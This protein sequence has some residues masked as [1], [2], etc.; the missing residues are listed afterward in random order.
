MELIGKV[1]AGRGVSDVDGGSDG[2]DGI[3]EFGIIVGG[4]GEL[5]D[6]GGLGGELGRVSGGVGG[7]GKII[8][9]CD[10]GTRARI[11][12]KWIG[13]GDSREGDFFFPH[14]RKHIFK[15]MSGNTKKQ[16]QD[17]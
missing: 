12:E 8:L 15:L 2:G 11:K 6:D 3:K 13:I 7:G 17:A 10:G 16:N 1:G 4:S 5:G 9:Y 14:T